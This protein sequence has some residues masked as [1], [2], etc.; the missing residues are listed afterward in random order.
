MANKVILAG[1]SGLIG[2]ALARTLHAQ[3]WE[4]VILTRSPAE[5]TTI[6]EVAWNGETGGAW[7]TELAD[8]TALVNLTGS[9]IN[10][11]HT[12]ENSREIL[13][14]RLNAVHALGKAL[15]KQKHAPAVWVQAS[16]VGYYGRRGASVCDEQTPPGQDFLAEVCRQWE[17]AFR[18]ACPGATRAVVLRLGVVLDRRGGAYPTLAQLTRRFLG[19]T[20]GSGEQ[21]FSWVHGSDVTQ[22]FQQAITRSEFTGAYNVCAPHPTTNRELMAALRRTLH[23][24]WVPPAPTF[25]VRLA[26]THLMQTDPSLVLDGRRC[27]PARL[28]AQ[29]F[30]FEFSELEGALRN[31]AA[32]GKS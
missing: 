29:G 2:R 27:V 21:G 28:Q 20:A 14:S 11:V 31:L 3:G 4:P 10:C 5:G 24:P 8:A 9:S 30:R 17:E 19:G 6:R 18:A 23:R 7:T 15:T 12:L 1:G 26:A 13:E 16:A 32:R 22:A 25:V